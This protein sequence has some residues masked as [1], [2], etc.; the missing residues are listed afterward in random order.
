MQST[1]NAAHWPPVLAREAADRAERTDWNGTACWRY[2]PDGQSRGRLLLIHGFRGDHHGLEAI[3]GALPDFEIWIPDLPGYGGSV[4]LKGKHDLSAY[5]DWLLEL[6]DWLQPDALVGHS[7]GTQ[8]I[9]CKSHALQAGLRVIL[10]NPIVLSS[11]AQRDFANRVARFSYRLAARLGK[12]GGSALRSWPLV[13]VMS[14][15][16]CKS[17]NPMLRSW[18][19]GQHHR[20]FSGYRSDRVAHEGFWAAAMG[21]VAEDWK[22]NKTIPTSIIAGQLD[23]IAP[24][25]RVSEFSRKIGA[26]LTVL[27]KTG[28]L[29]H[30]EAPSQVG[31]AIRDA[32]G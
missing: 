26:P 12:V 17:R 13:R 5:A 6:L 4:E 25:E 23:S 31:Q 19:H 7:F 14:M 28:H 16:M 21:N 29:V 2:Q 11:M 20:Y 22:V 8:I 18:V 24:V 1:R 10:I 9:A 32:I 3:V 27:Q 30:Y 15:A